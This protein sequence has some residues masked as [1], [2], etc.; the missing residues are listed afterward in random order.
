MVDLY[1]TVCALLHNY[2]TLNVMETIGKIFDNFFK[3][4]ICLVGK[5]IILGHDGA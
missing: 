5:D 3:S 1:S 4:Q 2:I